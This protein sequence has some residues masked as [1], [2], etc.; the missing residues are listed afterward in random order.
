M[1]IKKKTVLMRSIEARGR[2]PRVKKIFAGA[3]IF[4]LSGSL[5]FGQGV[6]LAA[7]I[8]RLEKLS[9]EGAVAQR[10]N[11]FLDL[12][13][14]RRLSGDSEGA[15][16]ICNSA[17]AAFSG[18]DQLLL[19]QVR[20]LVSMG[21]Y[22]KA[23]ITVSLLLKK[24][25]D[26]ELSVQG[27]YLSAQL[28]AFQSGNTDTLAALAEAPGFAGCRSGIYYTLWR[29]TSLLSWETRLA[30]EYPQS[31]E[32]KI[33]ASAVKSATSPL[34]LLF[35]GREGAAVS[36][37]VPAAPAASP[38]AVVAAK[39]SPAQPA[40]FLQAG[41]F[42]REENA[43][44][45]GERLKKAGFEPQITRRTMNGGDYWAVIV[46]GG[47]DMNATLAKLKDTGFEA[48]PVTAP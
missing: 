15:L 41:L 3:F 5:M 37:P 45:L 16:G 29:L 12:I 9:R 40:G 42:G 35:S 26:A 25:E 14:L 23:R 18:D 31:P 27:R 24:D 7:E 44:A 33:A 39:V 32:A 6:S 22:E 2:N 30:A 28:D 13:R 10:Y 43:R 19:E 46:S 47:K 11:A 38:L 8:S 1:R 34:W 17:V 21:E 48:F 4:L 20:L 36:V